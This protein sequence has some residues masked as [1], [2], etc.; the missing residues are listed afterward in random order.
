MDKYRQTELIPYSTTKK[1]FGK[2]SVTYKAADIW[3]I[4]DEAAKNQGLHKEDNDALFDFFL[5]MGI[6]VDGKMYP[7][8]NVYYDSEQGTFINGHQ[9]DEM[10]DVIAA[11]YK[12]FTAEPQKRVISYYLTAPSNV[13]EERKFHAHFR[14]KVKNLWI[15]VLRKNKN[16]ALDRRIAF[17][18]ESFSD[19]DIGMKKREQAALEAGVI[20]LMSPNDDEKYVFETI[21]EYESEEVEKFYKTAYDDMK[22]KMESVSKRFMNRNLIGTDWESS[23]DYM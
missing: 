1:I 17:M 6:I 13:S 10:M 15:D 8:A 4:F 20:G 23:I 22:S 12:Y 19:D 5:S 11:A 9:I 18:N 21:I 16:D 2:S 7:K 14:N 3:K